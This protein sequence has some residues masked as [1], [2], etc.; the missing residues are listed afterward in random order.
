M[1][2]QSAGSYQPD[3]Q[4]VI[5]SCLFFLFHILLLII[6]YGHLI[7]ILY[8]FDVINMQQ[9][10]TIPNAHLDGFKAASQYMQ[11]YMYD[12]HSCQQVVCV[13]V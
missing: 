4:L 9:F 10:A 6:N 12:L 7:S 11:C 5:C 8:E 1:G 3:M 2:N 13:F